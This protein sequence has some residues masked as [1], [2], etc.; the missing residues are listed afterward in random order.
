[1][2]KTILLVLVLAFGL[3]TEQTNADFTFGTPTKVPNVNISSVEV[4]NPE[5]SSDGLS[6]Y[7]SSGP[8]DGYGSSDIWMSTRKTIDDDWDTPANLGPPV[9]SSA[10]EGQPS[11]SA[12]GLELYF[13][14]GTHGN[15]GPY[16]PSGYGGSD[17]WVSM[18]P[19]TNDPWANPVNLGPIVN[20]SASD[21]DPE[22]SA[23]G[24]TLFFHSDRPGGY[25]YT[26]LW[27]TTRP[28]KDNHWA[29]PVNLGPT[30]NTWEY[31]GDPDVSSDGLSLFFC[32][33]GRVTGYG[34][35]DL[36]LSRRPTTNHPW[37]EP[38]NLGPIVNSTTDDSDP[39]ISADGSMLYFGSNRSG[40][41]ELWQAPIE[42]VVDLN[43]DRIV[44]AA[45][46]CIIVDHWGENDLLCDIA[47]MPW[48]DGIIDVQD[49]IVLA[50]HLFEEIFPIE[51]IAYWKL[52]EKEGDFAHNSI[53][54]N[55][56]IL[57][58]E[59]LWQPH[60]G[61]KS[62]ALEFDGIDD[63][64]ETGFVL[65][66]A[67]GAFSVFAWIKDGM[68]GQVIVS[69]TD[70]PGGAGEIWLGAGAVEGKLMTKLR[71]PSGRSPAPP[72]IADAIITDGHWH[73]AGI[74]VTEQK[75]RHLY[76][77]GIRAA[78]DTQPVLLPSSD[79]GLH[80]GAGKNFEAGTFFSGLI[81]DVRIYNKAL[82]ADE[83]ASLAQ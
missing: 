78:S 79:G 11:I 65:N 82:T 30:I 26:D 58:G 32:N 49:L 1:M 16:R 48:G 41:W 31:D 10:F 72:M 29:E 76:V 24:L 34:H 52:D 7:F 23:D 56:G 74:V 37:E 8:N 39:T 71:S 63:Y 22:I 13:A 53:S 57:H 69:Q 67:G 47:P 81:D 50:E 42:P 17:L 83:I 51:L 54:D 59:P 20:G 40:V 28:T 5:I 66:P 73:H 36:W 38:V 14:D 33:Y 3:V 60:N 61:Q 12:D 43:G 27:V 25:G 70:S 15:T 18:R 2:K 64:V 62:G 45:D 77:D 44:D 19:T 55:H 68:P 4:A 80:I 46:M 6:L 35:T 75:V 21:S 9:N